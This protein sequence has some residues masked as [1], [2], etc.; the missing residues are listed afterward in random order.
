MPW[1]GVKNFSAH[2]AWVMSDTTK[3]TSAMLSTQKIT[4]SAQDQTWGRS[5][6]KSC[7][8]PNAMFVMTPRK[9]A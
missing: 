7:I 3:P 9:I 2:C 8:S 1:N 4:F 6:A 5:A